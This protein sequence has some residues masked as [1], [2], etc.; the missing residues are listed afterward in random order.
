MTLEMNPLLSVNNT[1]DESFENKLF[2][3]FDFQQIMDDEGNDPDL[4]F[5]N[6]HSEAVSLP[7]YTIDEF[8]CPTKPFGKYIFYL[9][10]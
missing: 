3:P 9:T 5:F 6:D 1:L 2:N 4:I 10:D 8:S 7:Y